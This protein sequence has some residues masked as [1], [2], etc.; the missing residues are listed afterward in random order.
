MRFGSLLVAALAGCLAAPSVLAA[1]PQRSVQTVSRAGEDDAVVL[2]RFARCVVR[3]WRRSVVNVLEQVPGTPNER[4]RLS[5]A[6]ADWGTCLEPLDREDT[7]LVFQPDVMRGPFAEALYE[8][9][10]AAGQARGRSFADLPDPVQLLRRADP[11]ERSYRSAVVGIFAAC[12]AAQ[13]SA[14]VAA[15]LATR[16]A[17][18][19]EQAAIGAITP[20]F[21]G[22]FPAGSEFDITVPLLRG[23]LAEALYRQASTAAEATR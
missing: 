4:A 11:G 6:I 18:R 17:S 5:G 8:Q 15:L 22:C 1:D 19:E 2:D 10:F 13:H 3:G 20:A 21:G 23:F 12:V 16:P 14:E 9:D 7:R